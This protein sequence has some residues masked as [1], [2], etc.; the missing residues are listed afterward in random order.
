[1]R[2]VIFSPNASRHPNTATASHRRNRTSFCGKYFFF[3]ILIA[4]NILADSADPDYN[5]LNRTANDI[6][7]FLL[8]VE[9]EPMLLANEKSHK[10]K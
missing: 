1:M 2:A 5:T 8:M 10:C 4:T 7:I 6:L 9:V 3:I